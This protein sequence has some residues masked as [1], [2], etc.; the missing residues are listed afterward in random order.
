ME[1]F[2]AR[3]YWIIVLPL[4]YHWEQDLPR[5]GLEHFPGIWKELTHR[6]RICGT[7]ECKNFPNPEFLVDFNFVFLFDSILHVQSPCHQLQYHPKGK[8]RGKD[9]IL[10]VFHI[11]VPLA[12]LLYV[13]R[14]KFNYKLGRLL[15]CGALEDLMPLIVHEIKY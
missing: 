2:E 8:G 15:W 9:G 1:Y 3:N 11:K 7:Q 10:L 4:A 13:H 12:F 14:R 6:D 5:M